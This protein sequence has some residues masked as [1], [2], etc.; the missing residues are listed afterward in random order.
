MRYIVSASDEADLTEDG[1]IAAALGLDL[2]IS[3]V[4]LYGIKL[5]V[6]QEAV[7]M[8]AALSMD[9]TPFRM[10]SPFVHSPEGKNIFFFF[11]LFFSLRTQKN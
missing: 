2:K 9:K 7:A 6:P 8:A 3:Q 10:A 11:S 4:V 5:G 1:R